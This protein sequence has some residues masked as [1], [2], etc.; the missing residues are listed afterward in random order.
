MGGCQEPVDLGFGRVL[1]P[2]WIID[3]TRLTALNYSVLHTS[4]RMQGSPSHELK[5]ALNYDL[6]LSVRVSGWQYF[7][8]KL[9]H[10]DRDEE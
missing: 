3:K 6:R 1:A 8:G 2:L 9:L 4:V 5:S 10:I 7:H